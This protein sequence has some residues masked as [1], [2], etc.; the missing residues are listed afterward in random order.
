MLT[1]NI[2]KITKFKY[3]K[4]FFSFYSFF[5]LFNYIYGSNL[6][7]NQKLEEI[8][9]I[10]FYIKNILNP[11]LKCEYKYDEII[12]RIN[13]AKMLIQNIENIKNNYI[14]I[15]KKD[16]SNFEDGYKEKELNEIY[17]SSKKTL[18]SAKNLKNIF[19]KTIKILKEE[20]KK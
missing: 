18:E 6:N 3:L 8:K 13:S 20:L 4:N 7:T 15:L 10:E 11:I 19:D 17:E 16:F 14:N 9:K 12:L 5:Y 2:K 1:F